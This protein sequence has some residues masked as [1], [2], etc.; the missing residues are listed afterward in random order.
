MCLYE[1][2][3]CL[4]LFRLL[5]QSMVDWVAY[6]Q[7]F[8]SRSSGG[9][10]S[11][12]R[13]PAEL[14]TGEALFL[15]YRQPF[16]CFLTPQKERNGSSLLVRTLILSWGLHPHDLIASRRPYCKYH[17]IRASTHEFGREGVQSIAGGTH[18]S[19][20]DNPN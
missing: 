18:I 8:V 9:W 4:H 1:N 20:K 13:M 11:E 15:I 16:L 6:K 2:K 14:S 12:I 10:R 17:P 5:N 19:A 7:K 3:G